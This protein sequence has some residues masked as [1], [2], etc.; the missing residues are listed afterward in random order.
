MKVL[1]V[2]DDVE[3]AESNR[4]LL[5]AYGYE[6]AVAHDGQSGLKLAR[7]TR[8]DLMVLDVMMT[9]HTEGLDVARR[10]HE[11]PELRDMAVLLVTGVTTALG[12]SG[13][14]DPDAAWLPVD[15][16]LEKPIPPERLIREIERVLKARKAGAGE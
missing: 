12:V 6:V 8:P 3:F 16:V 4:D 11:S 14:L 7:E 5:E 1:I 13:K 15:R 2:D 9:T 10:I